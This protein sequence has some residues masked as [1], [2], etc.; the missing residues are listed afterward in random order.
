M[1]NVEAPEFPFNLRTEVQIR[2][3]DIDMLGHLNN[4]VY[5]QMM[6]IGKV[7]YFTAINGGPIE[8][9]SVNLVVAN[10]NVNY[11]KQTTLYEP[12][13]VLTRCHKLGTKSL[14]LHQQVVNSATG[15]VKADGYA[16]MVSIDLKSKITTPITSDWR[17]KL[18][19]FEGRQF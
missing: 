3:T 8:W 15:E 4:A 5:T 6:D 16:T 18:S 10:I 2:F 1:Q 19:A 11:L 14:V 9:G 13:E 17:Q 12:L 7:A